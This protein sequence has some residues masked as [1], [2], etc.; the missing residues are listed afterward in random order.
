M[1]VNQYHDRVY[2][3]AFMVYGGSRRQFDKMHKCVPL[4]LGLLLPQLTEC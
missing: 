1:Q 2:S 4:A 3:G